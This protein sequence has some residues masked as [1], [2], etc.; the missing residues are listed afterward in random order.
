MNILDENIPGG[1]RMLLTTWHVPFRQIGFELGQK[2]IKDPAIIPLLLGLTRPTFFTRD[3]DFCQRALCHSRY[4]LVVLDIDEAETAFYIRRLLRHP[5]FDTQFKRMGTVI[6][7][8]VT[9]LAVFQLR[10]VSEVHYAWHD[11]A[12]RKPG[13]VIREEVASYAMEP[14]QGERPEDCQS[15]EV[16]GVPSDPVL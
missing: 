10:T 8:S 14:S 13:P 16:S 9:G 15:D 4:S 7:V 11:I 3:L 12:G 2:G 6:R 1:Q 5:D